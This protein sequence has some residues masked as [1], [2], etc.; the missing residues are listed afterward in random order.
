[1]RKIQN[2]CGIIT[3]IAFFVFLFSLFQIFFVPES[4]YF[5][6]PGWDQMW[7]YR[8]EEHPY[9]LPMAISGYTWVGGIVATAVAPLIIKIV[10][11][12]MGSIILGIQ[13][14]HYTDKAKAIGLKIME[15]GEWK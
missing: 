6:W 13:Q 5:E 14:I 3:V 8:Q 10:T 11:L 2:I 1:M 12:L 4:W 7:R 15:F 9:W